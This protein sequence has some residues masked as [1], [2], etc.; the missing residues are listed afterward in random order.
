MVLIHI[1]S[2]IY[3]SKSIFNIW[4]IFYILVFNQFKMAS[5]LIRLWQ[6]K[7]WPFFSALIYSSQTRM[8]GQVQSKL[9]FSKTHSLEFSCTQSAYMA[10]SWEFVIFQNYYWCNGPFR[11]IFY[12]YF[13]WCFCVLGSGVTGKMY[14]KW[15]GFRISC[16]NLLILFQYLL[17]TMLQIQTI[18]RTLHFFSQNSASILSFL[19]SDRI[20]GKLTM[21]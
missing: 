14:K 5:C 3:D 11:Y 2:I 19:R 15:C 20:S 18:P 9:Y 10:I 1:Y 16:L 7:R 17:C 8:A 21:L 13:L 6:H 4:F 12:L